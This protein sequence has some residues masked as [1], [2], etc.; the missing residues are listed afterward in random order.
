MRRPLRHALAV[1][2]DAGLHVERIHQAGRHTEIWL[3]GGGCIRLHRGSRMSRAFER[4]LRST[5]R[6]WGSP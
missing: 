4:G 2:E 6:K 5:I 3:V 1:I